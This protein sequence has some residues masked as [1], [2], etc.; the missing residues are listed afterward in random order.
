MFT[1]LT[2]HDL[3]TDRKRRRQKVPATIQTSGEGWNGTDQAPHAGPF[4]YDDVG[5]A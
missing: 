5:V 3:K 2:K 4:I 1:Y